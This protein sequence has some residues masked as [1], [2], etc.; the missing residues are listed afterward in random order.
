MPSP[1]QLNPLGSGIATAKVFQRGSRAIQF[2]NQS[3]TTED[4]MPKTSVKPVVIPPA[5]LTLTSAKLPEKLM[6]AMLAANPEAKR[7][8]RALSMTGAGLR[9][10]E[11]RLVAKGLLTV[12][13]DRHMIHVPGLV[14]IERPA[15]G[16]FVPASP[17]TKKEKKVARP[18][19]K[20][21]Q[22]DI[23]PLVV[24]AELVA[25]KYLMASEKVV[26][27]YY[28]AHPAAQTKAVL[29]NLRLSRAGLKKL[30][31]ALTDKRVLIQ[32]GNGYTIR[33]PGL[34]LVQ[35]S[36]GGHF[37]P[38]SE[39]VK[40]GYKV[41][42][43]APKLTPAKDVYNRW[44]A[45]LKPMRGQPSAT[46]SHFLGLT[47]GKIKQMEEESPPGPEREHFLM[48]MKKA[49]DY[50]FA[51]DFVYD[52]I[53]RKYEEKFAAL[54]GSAT[55]DQLAMVRKKVEAMMLAGLPEPKLLGMVTK[56]ISQ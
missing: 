45:C 51:A 27:A 5:I 41:A 6:L 26:L 29:K 21:T 35:D 47:T 56:A 32:T 36:D 13:G 28:V 53:P 44:L 17:A 3:S 18:V 9:K 22:A 10:L 49:E 52:Y 46:P 39:V 12:A 43:P 50:Y 2:F 33:L 20:T 30:K 38:E 4:F 48:A 25:F 11:Q 1:N 7:V 34:V 40:K 54:I 37:V 14:Y 16:H 24:P 55:P 19:S 31:R 23:H 42:Y 15:A 8:F